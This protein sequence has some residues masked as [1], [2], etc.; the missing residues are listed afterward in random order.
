MLIAHWEHFHP[1][2]LRKV[3]VIDFHEDI[4]NQLLKKGISCTVGD[5]SSAEVIAKAHPYEAHL[6]ICSIPDTMLRG[7]T[8]QE[9]LKISKEVWPKAD[10]IVTAD[11]QGQVHL[12]Y[13]AG[14]D[15]VL[16]MAK[17]CAER[18]H[19]LIIDHSCHAVHHHH[20]Q[21]AGRSSRSF[22]V[23][24]QYKRGDQD[25]SVDK[26]QHIVF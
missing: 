5:I 24:E 17:L 10:V 21:D 8:N 20:H 15:Y 3:H 11:N 6:V 25:C 13:E 19:E 2:L 26:K 12:L 7:V 22:N 1:A 14:A 18:L 9:L 23:F 16:R 4:T